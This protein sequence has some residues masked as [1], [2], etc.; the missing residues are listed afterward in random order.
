MR[1]LSLKKNKSEADSVNLNEECGIYFEPQLDF[2]IGDTVEAFQPP[3][4][5][6][7]K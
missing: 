1:I 5:P 6:V 3:K 2:R 7:T 4:A